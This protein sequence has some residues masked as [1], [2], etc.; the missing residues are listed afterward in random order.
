MPVKLALPGKHN[1]SNA[2]IAAALTSEFDVSL[3]EIAS[4]LATMGEVKGRVNLIEASDSLTIIDD[5]YNANVKSVKAAIDLLSDIQGHRILHSV[6]WVNL[7]KMHVNIIKKSVN[8][9]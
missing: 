1:I 6:I 5:T 4:A 9:H 8:T 3:E 7:A 2:L